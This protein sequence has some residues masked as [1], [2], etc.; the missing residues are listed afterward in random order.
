[1]VDKWRITG[2]RMDKKPP[3]EHPGAFQSPLWKHLE[4]IR[5]LRLARKT[6][7]E[8]AEA[9]ARDHQIK[10]PASSI[11]R[12]FVRAKKAR[13]PAGMKPEPVRPQ[14]QPVLPFASEPSGVDLNRADLHDPDQPIQIKTWQPPRQSTP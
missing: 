5:S 12:F 13:L 14:P 9:L 2:Q 1:V 7:R 6:W 4:T 3:D 8:V 11:C 10:M